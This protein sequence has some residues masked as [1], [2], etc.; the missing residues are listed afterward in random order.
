M[1]KVK[2]T[3]MPISGKLDDKVY[4][5]TKHGIIVKAAPGPGLKGDQPAMTRQS[6]RTG[7]LNN[8][9]KEIN[10]IVKK[11]NARFKNAEF[12]TK[13]AERMRTEP[14]NN[15]FLLLKTLVGIDINPN[16]PFKHLRR[17]QVKVRKTKAGIEVLLDISSHPEPGQYEATCYDYE[18]YFFSWDKTKRTANVQIQLSQWISMESEPPEVVFEFEK[19]YGITHWLLMLRHRLGHELWASRGK[20]YVQANVAEG[21]QIIDVGSFNKEELAMWKA[22]QDEKLSRVSAKWQPDTRERKGKLRERG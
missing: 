11:H 17:E 8:L 18:A 10:D 7:Y 15:R 5:N 20:E 1:A 13:M 19:P 12:W 6:S 2:R 3:I 14:E 22:K 9:A 4:A 21:M 16:Y